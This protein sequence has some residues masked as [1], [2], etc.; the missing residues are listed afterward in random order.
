LEV[1]KNQHILILTYT[2]KI[3]KLGKQKNNKYKDYLKIKIS[4]SKTFCSIQPFKI[5]Q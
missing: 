4:V 3:K 2:I 5:K 1:N